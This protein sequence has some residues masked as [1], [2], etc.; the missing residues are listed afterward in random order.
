MFVIIHKDFRCQGLSLDLNY[1][2]KE[3]ESLKKFY[4]MEYQLNMTSEQEGIL[5]SNMSAL[6]IFYNAIYLL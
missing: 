6:L 5:C 2:K 4:R 3:K 1:I